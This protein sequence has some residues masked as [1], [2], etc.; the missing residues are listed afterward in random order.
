MGFPNDKHRRALLGRTAFPDF[1]W[2]FAEAPGLVYFVA[3]PFKRD[4][5][6]VRSVPFGHKD[7]VADVKLALG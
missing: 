6:C 4:L 2:R 7:F 1:F 5:Y 3:C